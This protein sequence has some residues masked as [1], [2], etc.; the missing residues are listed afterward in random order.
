MGQDW[1]EIWLQKFHGNVTIWPKTVVSDFYYILS[2]PSPEHLARMIHEGQRSTFGKIQFIA[3]RHKIEVEIM[4]GL[5]I[6]HPFLTFAGASEARSRA[7]QRQ[8]PSGRDT[9]RVDIPPGD[10]MVEHLSQQHPSGYYKDDDK[11]RYGEV[12]DYMS[13]NS[14]SHSNDS[15]SR[16]GN[17]VRELRRQSAVFFDDSDASYRD[18]E[19]ENLG[20][21][22]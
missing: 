22:Q 7:A 9:D 5:A 21:D 15:F 11:S 16:G 1:S 19:D 13:P 10:P 14:A 18:G 2:D 4:N 8:Q 17:F 12:P 3:N 6:C 20:H